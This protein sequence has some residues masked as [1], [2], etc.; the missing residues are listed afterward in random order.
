M[1][2]RIGEEWDAE[3]G[4]ENEEGEG[5]RQ[6]MCYHGKNCGV[7]NRVDC[8]GGSTVHEGNVSLK[9]SRQ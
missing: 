4:G 3:T 7:V 5:L 2:K 8:E 9:F 6:K 1:Q